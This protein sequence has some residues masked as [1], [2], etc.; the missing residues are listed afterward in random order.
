VSSTSQSPSNEDE[1]IAIQRGLSEAHGENSPL[2]HRQLEHVS[3][4]EFTPKYLSFL[5][6]PNEQSWT[7]DLF[8]MDE[9]LTGRTGQRICGG[10]SLEGLGE[11]QLRGLFRF[12][13][14]V[15]RRHGSSDDHCQWS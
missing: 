4:D 15:G 10:L 9:A 12:I 6:G 7:A 11:V 2:V 5:E 13:L 3:L 1:V 14:C 8:E